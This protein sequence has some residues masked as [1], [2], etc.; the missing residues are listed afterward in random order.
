MTQR[1]CTLDAVVELPV[2]LR[3]LLYLPP[4]YGSDPGERWPL[5]LFLHGMG[6]R[7]DD[8]ERVKEHG[9]PRLVEENP[10]FPFVA[11][12]PQCPMD[13][14]WTAEL[15][16]LEA[17]LDH[18]L[19]EYAVDPDRVYLTGLS[20]GGYGAW[21]LAAK[22]PHRF[23]AVAPICGG[24]LPQFGFPDRASAL[25]EVPVWAFHGARD[26]VVPLAESEKMVR[27]LESAGGNVRLTVYP[28]CG[29]NSWDEAYS[30]PE[31][32]RWFLSHKRH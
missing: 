31:L 13:S 22:A 5:I 11:I 26:E 12:S 4:G 14:V 10:D 27:H 1:E 32:Y 9:I 24:G 28:E 23:A 7:G 16:A 2:R 29:H 21:H 6:E 18:A 19:Q 17:L 8:L 3:Y 20:M 25:R 15:H 30:N